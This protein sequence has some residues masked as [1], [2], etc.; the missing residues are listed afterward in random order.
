MNNLKAW[1]FSRNINKMKEIIKHN[2]IEEVKGL[3]RYLDRILYLD[4]IIKSKKEF[5]EKIKLL[6]SRLEF[7]SPIPIHTNSYDL[8]IYEMIK[9]VFSNKEKL[10]K[11]FINRENMLDPYIVLATYFNFLEIDLGHKKL[12]EENWNYYEIYKNNMIPRI[13]EFDFE[14]KY[15]KIKF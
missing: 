7:I 8:G 4:V 10:Y 6:K 12:D 15:Y 1:E 5:F 2:G 13:L 11:S 3:H 14:G 9:I